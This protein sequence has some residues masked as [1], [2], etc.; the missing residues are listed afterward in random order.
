MRHTERHLQAAAL[1]LAAVLALPGC[2]RHPAPAQAHTQARFPLLD[3]TPAEVTATVPS[4]G[5]A[6]VVRGAVDYRHHRA[7]ASYEGPGDDAG[8][9]AWDASGVAVAHSAVALRSPAEVLREAHHVPRA[10]WTGRGYASGALDTALRLLLT[11]GADGRARRVEVP[12]GT[13]LRP[14]VLDVTGARLR[15]TV[16]ARP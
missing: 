14:V 16:P 10:A 1:A 3:A 8:L 13:S 2:A 7:L 4:G 15:G 6:I 5:H 11:L 9:L 12:T